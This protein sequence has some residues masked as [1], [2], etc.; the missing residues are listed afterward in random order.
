MVTLDV[1]DD[2]IAVY[3]DKSDVD[4]IFA[5]LLENAVKYTPAGGTI[6]FATHPNGDVIE[7]VVSDTGIGVPLKDQERIFEVFYRAQGA[8]E[9]GEEGTGMGLSIV[10]QLVG[11][12]GG[13]VSLSSTPGQ[14]SRFAVRL[15]AAPPVPALFRGEGPHA[16]DG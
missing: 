5:N 3:A 10:R 7:T 2:E 14:G 8:K 12:W 9:S 1:P 11:R 16:R 15:P 6:T 4:C 13:E